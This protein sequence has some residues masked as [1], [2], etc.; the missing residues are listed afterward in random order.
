MKCNGMEITSTDLLSL[1]KTAND[2]KEIVDGARARRWATDCGPLLR[3]TTEWCKFY[4]A[5]ARINRDNGDH[6]A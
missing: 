2:L 3:D 5:L 4:T 1:V 6:E